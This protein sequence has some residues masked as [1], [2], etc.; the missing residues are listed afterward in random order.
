MQYDTLSCGEGLCQITV[1]PPQ[2]CPPLATGQFQ[3]KKFRIDEAN[4]FLDF[5]LCENHK[6]TKFLCTIHTFK[7]TF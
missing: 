4:F 1:S 3:V 5:F 6:L 2:P 7:V